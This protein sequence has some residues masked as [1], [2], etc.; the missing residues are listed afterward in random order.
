MVYLL[1]ISVTKTV[2]HLQKEDGE[3]KVAWY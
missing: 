1:M 3:I 2:S